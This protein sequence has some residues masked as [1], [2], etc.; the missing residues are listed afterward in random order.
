MMAAACLFK[1]Y[2]IALGLLLA[3]FYPRRF[4]PRFALAMA[5]GLIL[6]FALQ[7]PRYV[8]EQYSHWANHLHNDNDRAH[9]GYYGSFRDLRLLAYYAGIDMGYRAYQVVQL[10]L[11]LA[12]AGYCGLAWWKGATERALLHL[13]LGL[14]CCWMTVFGPA[15]EL[16]TYGLV[17]PAIAVLLIEGVQRHRHWM[18]QSL[19]WGI[20]A[21]LCI[22]VLAGWF[23][24][25]HAVFIPPLQ[26]LAT[27]VLF[28]C[29]LAMGWK[30]ESSSVEAPQ[31]L[32]FPMA[33]AA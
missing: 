5:V 24:L 30:K 32:E 9:L 19:V 2:P 13:M 21:V 10:V 31:P 25:Q 6:P 23:D 16:C 33:R 17:A 1:G 22:P 26:P 12:I 7:H 8:L 20:Y 15:T 3:A 14:S 29:L 11:G 4:A 28:V 27:L 18:V